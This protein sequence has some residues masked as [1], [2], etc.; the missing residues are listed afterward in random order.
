LWR[1]PDSLPT[2]YDLDNPESFLE[3]LRNPHKADDDMDKA[4]RD[5]L[6]EESPT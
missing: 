2:E 3:K 1:H 4:L 5:L 6:D